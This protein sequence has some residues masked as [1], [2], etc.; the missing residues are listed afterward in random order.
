MSRLPKSIWLYTLIAVFFAVFT[1]RTSVHAEVRAT[2]SMD[3]V[4]GSAGHVVNIP[5]KLTNNNSATTLQFDIKFNSD[6]LSVDN[7]SKPVIAES[8]LTGAGFSLTSRVINPGDVRIVITPPLETPVPTIPNGEIAELPIYI[9][10]NAPE[11][12]ETVTFDSVYASDANNSSLTIGTVSGAIKVLV[13]QVNLSVDETGM[14]TVKSNPEGI[15]CG[16]DCSAQFN[17]GSSVTLTATPEEGYEFSNWGGGCSS[18][19]DNATCIVTMDSDK[20]CSAIFKLVPNE[21]PVIDSLEAQPTEGE[22]PLTVSFTC[23]A[24]DSDGYVAGYYWD[25]NG[26]G[27]YDKYTTV[28][29]A[30]FTYGKYGVYTVNVKAIDNDNASSTI[31][32]IE[33]K[34]KPKNGDCKKIKY[35][36]KGKNIEI[37]TGNAVIDNAT[38]STT[39]TNFKNKPKGIDLK[40][41]I[42]VALNLTVGADNTTITISDIP[43]EPGMVFYKYVNGTWINLDNNTACGN[44]NFKRTDNATAG[45]TTISF[46]VTDGGPLDADNQTNGKIE[47]PVVVGTKSSPSSGGGGGGGGCTVSNSPSVGLL[48]IFLTVI[49]FGIRRR[50]KGR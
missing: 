50:F 3:N 28:P 34:V 18:C 25:F 49:G 37:I 35:N 47:D 12:T 41:E 26:D 22:K 32:S 8:T 13:E 7:S 45:T 46:V 10:S 16:E 24:T 42:K 9:K 29:Y 21:P 36:N 33:V 31:K 48:L 43:I 30:K 11:G 20:T 40:N 2:L 23:K 1:L 5:I 17:K 19:G 44:C 6:H 4:S 38:V 27:K 39:F 14:G 15:N